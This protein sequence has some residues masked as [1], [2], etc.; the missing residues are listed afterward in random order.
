MSVELDL[1]GQVV[2]L[3]R[4]AGGPDVQA[5]AYVS[6]LDLALT[7]FANSA[8]HQNV[9]ESTTRVRLR[10]H[11]DGRTTVGSSS[12]VTADGLRDLVDRTLAM[13]RLAPRDPAWPGLAPPAAVST[14][15]TW[16]EATAHAS[17]DERAA[18]V[19]AFV[20]AAEGLATAGYCRTVGRSAAMANSAGQSATGRSTDAAID[21]VARG[22][23]AAGVARRAGVRLAELDGARLGARAAAKAR[24]SAAPV[25]LPPQEYEVVLE[26]SAVADLLQNLAVFGFNGKAYQEQRSFVEL[27]AT[28]FD[29]AITLVDD[30]ETDPALPFDVEGTPRRIL[31]LVERGTTRAVAHDRRT[32]AQMGAVSTGHAAQGRMLSG[33][34]PVNLRL[35]P[36][37]SDG[38]AAADAPALGSVTDADT[39]ALVAQVR[40]GLLV[41][42][43]WYTRVLDPKTL[44]VTGLTRNGVWLIEDGEITAAVRDLRFTQSYPRALA[45]GAVLGMG[46][47][48][49]R[50]PDEW[51]SAWW[52]A[53]AVRLAAWNFT[54]GAS[55]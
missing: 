20:A 4:Q 35:L 27:G 11:V 32:A 12:L 16:D 31:P 19:G 30:P 53:P 25:E 29:A 7:R 39:A 37:G 6:R 13:A 52:S 45:P 50:Q 49:V 17:P 43:L 33:P 40:R 34:M 55:G 38:E 10:V 36:A 44:V 21:G 9:A 26:P 22:G 42:D 18:Q 23:G 47:H 48:V 3:V 54:G 1:A 5:E 14:Y 41:T 51:D 8:I 15:D 24:A 2:E 28:Q 46:R